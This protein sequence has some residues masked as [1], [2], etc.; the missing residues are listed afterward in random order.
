[1]SPCI[2]NEWL[3]WRS[4]DRETLLAHHRYNSVCRN[5]LHCE[6]VMSN[7]K[8]PDT[9]LIIN[10]TTTGVPHLPGS[11]NWYPGGTSTMS[12]YI[13]PL[14]VLLIHLQSVD[15]VGEPVQLYSSDESR[16]S[17]LPSQSWSSGIQPP[18]SHWN[19]QDVQSEIT[20]SCRE[21]LCVH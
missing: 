16:Q 21:L 4:L 7:I 19:S 14:Q 5:V 11:I 9:H 8:Q 20:A 12:L 1:M 6:T 3:S 15:V 2:I 10:S 13:C 17:S 18:S